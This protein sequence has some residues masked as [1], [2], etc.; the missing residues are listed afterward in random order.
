MKKKVFIVIGSFVFI[1]ALFIGICKIANSP[2]RYFKGEIIKIEDN[3]KHLV[4]R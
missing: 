2:V 4:L 3:D 1:I